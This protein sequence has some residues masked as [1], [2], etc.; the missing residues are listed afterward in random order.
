MAESQEPYGELDD[1]ALDRLIDGGFDA[2]GDAATVDDAVPS[3]LERIQELAGE[4]P[5]VSLRDA[6]P[7]GH[8]PRSEQ[9]SDAG[10]CRGKY[11][12]LGLLGH[13]GVGVVHR[14]RD[15]DLGRD[16]AMKF[17]RDG[18]RDRPEILRRF[19]EEAQIGGQLQHPGIVP[20]Y[21]LGVAGDTP[22][23]T[24]KL[25]D[26]R[27]L[28]QLLADRESPAQDRRHFLAIF[29]QV[30]Q[31]MAYAHARGV[32][33][34]D[35]KPSNVMVGAFGEVQVVDWGMGRVLV[36]SGAGD[37]AATGVQPGPV[38]TVRST[39]PGTRSV[40]GQVMGTPAYMPPEQARGLVDQMDERSDVFALG[41]ILCEILT[42]APPY[43][44]DANALISMAARP[45]LDSA[46]A[47]LARCEADAELVDLATRCL[48]P[49]LDRRPRSAEIV[50]REVHDHLA[51]VEARAHDARVEAAKA[52]VRAS[53][54]K[55]MQKLGTAL[56][57]VI[58][59]GLAASLWFWR[60][61]EAQRGR[62]QTNLDNFDRL[63]YVVRLEIAR[64]KEKS[65]YPAWPDQAVAM[66]AW[67]DNDAQPLLDALPELRRT[68]TLLEAEAGPTTDVSDARHGHPR[69]AE[70]E[71]RKR[72]LAALQRARAVRFAGAEPESF[73]LD[74]TSLP[75]S[76]EQLNALAWNLVAP[77]RNVFGR[78]AEGLAIARLARSKV[79]RGKG[80]RL[81][82]HTLAWALFDNGLDDAALRE[83]RATLSPKS[84]ERVGLEKAV[85][86]AKGKPGL[87]R[88][89]RVTHEVA[90][91]EATID[92]RTLGFDAAD[93]FLHAT[94]R[95]L[96][97]DITV[98]ELTDVASVER[99]LRWAERV[100]E[101]TV[102]RYHDRWNEARTAIANADGKTASRRY[103]ESP[104]ELSPQVGLVPIGMNPKTGLWEFY[105]PRS[106]WDTNT[107]TDPAA[108]TIP[109]HDPDGKLDM[110][111]RGM[112]FVLIPGGKFY[113]GAQS[114]SENLPNYDRLA[115]K[116][117]SPVKE[118]ELAPYFLSK[119]ELTQ[120]QWARLSGGEYPSFY[121]LGGD[122]VGIGLVG[123]TH[124]VEQVNWE[125]CNALLAR[126]GLILPTEAQWERACRAGT[127]TPWSSG[128]TVKELEG[129]ANVF[130][131]RADL[132]RPKWLGTGEAFDDGF[133]GPSPVGTYLPNAFGLYDMHGNVCEWCRD[134]FGTYG[135]PRRPGDGLPQRGP[136]SGKRVLRGGCNMYN[137]RFARS[138]YRIPNGP[139]FADA[140]LGV[141]PAR[142]IEE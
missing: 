47:R 27:T 63:S 34:R 51:A 137:A 43:V 17:L 41:A 10:K 29:E 68:L 40:M 9:L 130:D 4:A 71:A 140:I 89:A 94:L 93:A 36:P 2:A 113:M 31:T 97:A 13:G 54:L 70:L 30:C 116:D 80:L 99:R 28:A 39:D 53:A 133:K 135:V 60:D 131:R 35:L 100:E 12:V 46:L 14:G 15:A 77:G 74:E 81:V 58:A 98:F 127:P 117:E 16:V 49:S 87:D 111:G 45:E 23:F 142:A 59:L 85:R 128:K 44:G 57:V 73:V 96:I 134:M 141:R 61:A 109:S 75:E 52:N 18:F 7:A 107:T 83:A 115:A 72:E 104:I 114:Q 90:D 65:L 26:G 62:A 76:A 138:S 105:H 69:S 123:D 82:A 139:T 88:L 20:V 136:A 102:T 55:R 132:I 3:V 92:T 38:E 33:H 112:V 129:F 106:A 5:R 124:P 56:I 101:L 110:N 25:V 37:N 1:E 66:R 120:G 91:L 86:E 103:A 119:Y 64:A 95:R 22:F 84:A 6:R 121:R 11:R 50:A 78:E 48:A 125:G 108:L 19:V 42:G 67:L 8:T 126:H 118:V 24:M 32:V 21:D 122:Y 79:K